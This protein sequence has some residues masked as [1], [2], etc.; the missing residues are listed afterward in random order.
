VPKIKFQR[1]QSLNKGDNTNNNTSNKG[2]EERRV[3]KGDLE[4]VAAGSKDRSSSV[5]QANAS[6]ITNSGGISSNLT[7]SQGSSGTAVSSLASPKGARASVPTLA[8]GSLVG[9][10]ADD[11][12]GMGHFGLTQSMLGVIGDLVLFSCGLFRCVVVLFFGVCFF[13]L[14][15]LLFFFFCFFVFFFFFLWCC[16][17]ILLFVS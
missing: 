3:S 10:G 4:K 8:M 6:S 9:A 7:G 15:R 14:V 2:V 1:K 12:G 16:V 11:S 13:F 17:L 5:S